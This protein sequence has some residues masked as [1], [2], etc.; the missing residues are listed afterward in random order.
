MTWQLARHEWR[1]TRASL[2][3]WLL[4][5][6]GQL[7]IAWLVFAQLESYSRI[8]PQLNS[9][10]STLSAT[11]LIIAPTFGSLVLLLLL[12]VP[13]LAQGG[14]A[15]EGRSGRLTLWLSAPVTSATLVVSRVIGVFLS[16]LPLLLT[17]V[18]TLALTG[19]G[20]EL[21]WPRF[22]LGVAALLVYTLWLASITVSLSTWVEHPAAVLALS[23]GV[24]L[25]L[26]LL[27]SFITAESGLHW[28]A[29]L[30]H[31]Q[32]AFAGLLRSVDLVYLL[33]TGIAATGIAIYRV[34]GW[35]GEV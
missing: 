3:F 34:A 27:D 6:V 7:T 28:A 8:A 2:L 22:L 32:P 21:D 29:L 4:L 10:G 25:F 9:A 12:A 16:T 24:L 31:L 30:P 26:W 20:I 14:L 17:A 35:R 1:R 23:Y 19:L 18:L 11:D 15:G 13:L 5:T 33:V